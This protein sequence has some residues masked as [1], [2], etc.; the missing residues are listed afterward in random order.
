MGDDFVARA[1]SVRRVKHAAAIKIRDIF[2]KEPK[3]VVMEFTSTPTLKARLNQHGGLP[4]ER[5]ADIIAQLAD[6]AAELHQMDGQP[7]LGPVRPSYVH[8]ELATKNVQISLVHITNE[9][10]K[11][12]AQR[13]TLLLDSEELTYLI[14]E[15]YS[16]RRIEAQADQYYL[17][18]LALELLMGKPPVEVL[19][20]ADLEIK[21]KFFDSPRASF[22][23]LLSKQPA[24]SF[25]LTRMLEQNPENRWKSMSELATVLREV[26][27]GKVPNDV[28]NVAIKTYKNTLKNNR[29]FFKLFY[30]TLK[31]SSDEIKSAFSQVN[32]DEQYGNLEAALKATLY[33]DHSIEF[34]SLDGQAEKHQALGLKE[35]HFDLFKTY[36]LRALREMTSEDPYSH[37]AWGAILSP[38]LAFMSK[39]VGKCPS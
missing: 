33:F 11:S 12:C 1:D 27:A 9:V 30:D 18:L 29:V 36:F 37:D 6:L 35:E 4:F 10:L 32:M 38:A 7:I 23:V 39:K 15:R 34:T 28:K 16:G 2:R 24:F 3:C 21:R 20:F 31:D 5:V 22:G 14:P 13:P 17:G 26:V 8:Y 19:S 25:V